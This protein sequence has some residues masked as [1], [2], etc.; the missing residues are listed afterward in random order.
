MLCK[1]WGKQIVQNFVMALLFAI[2]DHLN[3]KRRSP[4][5]SS[6]HL[7]I[8]T[9]NYLPINGIRKPL[10]EGDFKKCHNYYFQDQI[11]PF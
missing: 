6:Q 10:K 1:K 9:L 11:H 8:Y 4:S 5:N 7:Q 2:Y 3:I